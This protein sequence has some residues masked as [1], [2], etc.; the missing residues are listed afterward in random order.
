MTKEEEIWCT[1]C[2]YFK[3]IVDDARDWFGALCTKDG[4]ESSPSMYAIQSLHNNCPL[5][6]GGE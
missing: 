4:H 1:E 6:K 2:P 5:M 3:D